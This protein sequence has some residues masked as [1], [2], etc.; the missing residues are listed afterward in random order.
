MFLGSVGPLATKP[1]MHQ[2]SSE[3]QKPV[4]PAPEKK[5]EEVTKVKETEVLKNCTVSLESPVAKLPVGKNL[6]TM[7][8]KG[9]P[10]MQVKIYLFKLF[11]YFLSSFY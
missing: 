3:T 5:S 1:T 6:V 11:S 9:H 8:R 7:T 10:V 2:L 4:L